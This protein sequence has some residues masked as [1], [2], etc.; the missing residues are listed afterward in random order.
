MSVVK[1]EVNNYQVSDIVEV[2][3][4]HINGM[5]AGRMI[6][7]PDIYFLIPDINRVRSHATMANV[8]CKLYEQEGHHVR[9]RYIGSHQDQI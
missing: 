6:D 3:T 4:H 8:I 2:E 9:A 1:F 5:I 7:F